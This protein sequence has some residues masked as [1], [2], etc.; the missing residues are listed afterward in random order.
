MSSN[1]IPG[2]AILSVYICLSVL[3]ILPTAKQ[4]CQ[5]DQF[6]ARLGPLFNDLHES[7]D[8]SVARRA[9]RKIWTIWHESPDEKALEIMREARSHI[10][11]NEYTRASQLLD[12]LVEHAPNFA[13]AWNQR[14]IVFFLD[15]KYGASLRDIEQTLIL[16][17]R[18]FGALSG[19]AQVYIRLDEPELALKSFQEALEQNPWMAG[20]RQQME[21]VRA[22]LD[23]QQK[24]I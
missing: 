5:A 2:H 10:D 12:K 3:L 24:P 4:A 17:P 11:N 18:H 14:A 19:R 9:E 20:V 8:L 23:S 22:Y 15:G 1:K 21:M 7:K 13:E 6:D 16:E